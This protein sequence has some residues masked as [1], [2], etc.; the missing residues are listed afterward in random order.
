LHGFTESLN[1]RYT[2]ASTYQ[3]S[4][5]AAMICQHI[6]YLCPTA[7]GDMNE[8]RREEIK[9]EWLAGGS[10]STTLLGDLSNIF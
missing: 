6:L 8:E 2:C 1:L 5:A 10:N 4:V 7:R 9:K 3:E